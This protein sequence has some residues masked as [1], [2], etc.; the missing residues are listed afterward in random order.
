MTNEELAISVLGR[1]I[2]MDEHGLKWVIESIQ[3]GAVG[4]ICG[5][6][7]VAKSSFRPSVSVGDIC[8]LP[9]RYLTKVDQND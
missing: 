5:V 3:F 4:P 6:R 8:S 1:T 9:S 2:V 7:C